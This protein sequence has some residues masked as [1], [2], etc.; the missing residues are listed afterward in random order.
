MTEFGAV[1]VK[2]SIDDFVAHAELTTAFD[3]SVL[4]CDTGNGGAKTR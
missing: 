4:T 3:S 1:L 2:Q